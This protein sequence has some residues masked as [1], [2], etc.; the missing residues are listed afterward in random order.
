M[1]WLSVIILARA[2]PSPD[3]AA[4]PIVRHRDLAT[5][6]QPEL[7]N[8]LAVALIRGLL[9]G[10]TLQQVDGLTSPTPSIENPCR[11]ANRQ[12]GHGDQH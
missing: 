2:G 5:G 4:D 10:T 6:G 12:N 1:S 3:A 9:E 8:A 7:G 11:S